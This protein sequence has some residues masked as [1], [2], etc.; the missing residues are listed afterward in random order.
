MSRF[1][2]A[3]A[4]TEPLSNSAGLSIS[5]PAGSRSTTSSF[6]YFASVSVTFSTTTTRS[7][8]VRLLMSNLGSVELVEL[9]LE[10]S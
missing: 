4:S 8:C 1:S 2:Q 7:F 10:I 6:A 3:K 5:S 9:A